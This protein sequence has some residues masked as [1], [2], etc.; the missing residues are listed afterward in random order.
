M[1]K[2]LWWPEKLQP[3]S[4]DVATWGAIPKPP[5][6]SPKLAQAVGADILTLKR[7]CRVF[8]TIIIIMALYRRINC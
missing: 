5:L 2:P 1:V 6:T 4:T 7:V 8:I 3:E